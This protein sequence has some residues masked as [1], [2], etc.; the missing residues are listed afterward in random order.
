M[1]KEH[2]DDLEL[3]L[4]RL[5]ESSDNLIAHVDSC[6]Q[7]QVKLNEFSVLAEDLKE[8]SEQPDFS[9]LDEQLFKDRS[10]LVKPVKRF[11]FY[12]LFSGLAAIFL[13][14]FGLMFY[15]Y[16][17]KINKP[18]NNQ[19][20]TPVE[21]ADEEIPGDLN[22]DGVVDVIDSYLFAKLLEGGETID[23]QNLDINKDG[24]VDRT[25]LQLLSD[26]IVEREG[27]QG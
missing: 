22:K 27:N 21:L 6:E 19:P 25:D 5:G 10:V 18:A 24:T 13:L 2:P 3:E 17:P 15:Q 26:I 12:R 7:C 8:L 14:G 1:N 16:R 11:P 9:K 20:G 4:Y 23:N